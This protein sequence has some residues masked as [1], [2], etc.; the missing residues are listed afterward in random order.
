MSSTAASPTYQA[1]ALDKGL[2]VLE[3]LASAG[4]PLT[5]AEIARGLDRSPSE[6]FR[7]LTVLERRGYLLREGAS[8]SYRL[9]LRLFELGARHSPVEDLLLAAREPMQRLMDQTRESC[10]LSVIHEG[11]LLVVAQVESPA[12][13]RLSVAVGSTIPLLQ[14]VSGRVLLAHSPSEVQQRLLMDDPS[15]AARTPRQQAATRKIL[16]EIAE[17]GSADAHGETVAGVSDLAVLV[18]SATTKT[19]AALAVSGLPRDH[20]RWVAAC[21]PELKRAAADIA[22][23]VG[24]ANLDR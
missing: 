9:T 5:Q 23:A 24:I 22:T 4:G 7:V 15:W 20:A 1:P 16:R 17:R 10:H 14:G 11:H 6:L 19:L 2:D 12:R 21:L 8:G 13:V 3:L 18:G